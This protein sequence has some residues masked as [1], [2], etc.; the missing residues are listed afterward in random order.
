MI[1]FSSLYA[2]FVFLWCVGVKPDALPTLLTVYLGVMAVWVPIRVI[3]LAIKGAKPPQVVEKIVEKP[4]Y[5]DQPKPP[6]TVEPTRDDL[7]KK[8]N[9][10][11]QTALRLL[12]SAGLNEGELEAARAAAKQRYLRDLDEVMK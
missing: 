7:M 2:L 4:V 3:G 11:Y 1:R 9:E 12:Q 8:A 5:L 10:K 6:V